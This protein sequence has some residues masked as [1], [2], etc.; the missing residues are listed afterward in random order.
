MLLLILLPPTDFLPYPPN[1]CFYQFQALPLCHYTHTKQ[2][3]DGRSQT[4]C[5]LTLRV[6]Q[7]AATCSLHSTATWWRK[8][9]MGWWWAFGPNTVLKGCTYAQIWWKIKNRHRF[10]VQPQTKQ[11]LKM[12]LRLF[13]FGEITCKTRGATLHSKCLSLTYR[14]VESKSSQI[15]KAA[16]TS[17][18]VCTVQLLITHLLIPSFCC[19]RTW[20]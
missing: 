11:G 13:T 17:S 20:S 16:V 14:R 10:S 15:R 4:S 1:R 7:R 3:T 5:W 19:E 12:K 9:S 2:G 6:H 8:T 18:T